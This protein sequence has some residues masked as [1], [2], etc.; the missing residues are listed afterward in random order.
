M[1][2][3][4][5]VLCV[6]KSVLLLTRRA[7][8]AQDRVL[9]ATLQQNAVASRDGTDVFDAATRALPRSPVISFCVFYPGGFLRSAASLVC[10]LCVFSVSEGAAPRLP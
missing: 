8:R 1:S 7:C 2:E 4:S 10:L 5:F 3:R 6:P 9:E